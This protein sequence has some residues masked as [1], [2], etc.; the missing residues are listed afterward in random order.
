MTRTCS[1]AVPSFES[2]PRADAGRIPAFARLGEAPEDR[3]VGGERRAELNVQQA[4]LAAR[5]DLR[6]AGDG[7]PQLTSR[8][9]DAQPPGFSVTSNE[10]SGRGSTDQGLTRPVATTV[11]SKATLDFASQTRVW[12]GNAGFCSGTFASRVSIGVH[13]PLAAGLAGWPC[14]STELPYPA[15]ARPATTVENNATRER[16]MK[17]P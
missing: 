11:T 2:T 7:R 15:A 6:K 3:P 5:I 17:A 10:P 14:P 8:G 9:D 13:A 1:S 16:L 12:P 4:A